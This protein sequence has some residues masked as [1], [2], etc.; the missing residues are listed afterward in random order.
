MDNE[1]AVMQIQVLD[2]NTY[3]SK[4]T[5]FINMD[6]DLDWVHVYLKKVCGKFPYINCS[7]RKVKYV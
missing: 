4:R 7:C 5:I 3:W 6:N 2:K 1:C